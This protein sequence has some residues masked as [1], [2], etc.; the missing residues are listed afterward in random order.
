MQVLSRIL[1][2]GISDL[3]V[4]DLQLER[5]A[6]RIEEMQDGIRNQFGLDTYAARLES[7]YQSALSSSKECG[8]GTDFLDPAA[9]LEGFLGE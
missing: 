5:S 9:V 4:P 8:G 1:D 3:G 6:A 7:L 2:E